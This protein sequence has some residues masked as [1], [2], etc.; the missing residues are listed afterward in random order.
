MRRNV[1]LGALALG[2]NWLRGYLV[3][4]LRGRTC[5][6]GPMAYRLQTCA[7]GPLVVGPAV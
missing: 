3:V 1:I 5:G 7:A 2:L 4:R 6:S